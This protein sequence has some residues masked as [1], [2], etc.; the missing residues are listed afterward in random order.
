M[1]LRALKPPWLWIYPHSCPE[2]FA[3]CGAPGVELKSSFSGLGATEIPRDP[4]AESNLAVEL[5]LVGL[6]PVCRCT[7]RGGMPGCG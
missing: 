3:L 2:L 7:H 6:N 4:R 1:F 5:A